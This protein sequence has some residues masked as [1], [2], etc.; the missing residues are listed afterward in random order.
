LAGAPGSV[1]HTAALTPTL[2][3]N[4]FVDP[5]DVQAEM[6]VLFY[7]SA[8]WVNRTHRETY[9]GEKHQ[10]CVLFDVYGEEY[11]ISTNEPSAIC[12][13]VNHRYAFLLHPWG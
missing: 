7:Q 10:S 2:A 13:H 12:H 11:V 9:L 4:T 6:R 3:L 8:S 1:V 5:C